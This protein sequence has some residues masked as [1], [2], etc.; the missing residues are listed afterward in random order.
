MNGR[1]QLLGAPLL[2]GLALGFLRFRSGGLR[3]AAVVPGTSS[4][5]PRDTV[6][7]AEGQVEPVEP[8]PAVGQEARELVEAARLELAPGDAGLEEP[9]LAHVVGRFVLPDGRPAVGVGLRVHGWGANL[10]R[11]RKYG[12]PE[13][14]VD[15]EG[16][17]GED[18]SFDLAFDPPQAYQFTL[19]ASL[20]GYAELS[21]RWSRLEPGA[22]LD[23][24]EHGFVHPGAIVGRVLRPDGEPAGGAWR[25][26]ADSSYQPAGE[27]GDRTRVS[28]SADP[29]DGSFRLEG[30]PPGSVQLKA[31]LRS[32]NWID[33]PVVQLAAHDELE[34][35]IVYAGPDNS[36]RIT[37]VT[38]SR[39]FYVFD[40]PAPGSITATAS[41]GTVY[42]AHKIQGSSQ[43]HSFEELPE[44]SYEL[45]IDDE[46]YL[47]WSRHGVRPGTSVDA[48]LEGSAAVRLAVRDAETGESVDDYA[49]ALRF[50]DVNFSPNMFDVRQ[51]GEPGRGLYAGLI[52]HATTL[53]VTAPGYARHEAALGE[54]APHS[55]VNA[56][57]ELARG[58]VVRGLVH[59]KGGAPAP[60]VSILMTPHFP[61]Y[62][63]QD[64]FSGP[65]GM[66]ARSA[67]QEQSRERTS[68]AHGR[69][70]FEAVP[71]GSYD[72][73]ALQGTVAGR[74]EAV[75]VS[76]GDGVE[77]DIELPG[78]GS[79]A[80]QVRLPDG[81][82]RAGLG[83]RAVAGDS[84]QARR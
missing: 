23:V 52:P 4:E 51:A 6:E 81:A 32:A 17:T 29:R 48:H 33:G 54:L 64:V 56:V 19:D 50:E 24:G 22:T 11:Q 65:S 74:T 71:A 61:G 1:H 41:D 60:G 8:Q 70:S 27:G 83:L 14:W 55:T 66:S 72:F 82:V 43:S 36:R 63:P 68:D 46:R 80:G 34:A 16:V 28:T 9:E 53:I 13:A 76:S 12:E 59:E 38:L 58:S 31:Y 77:V 39:P 37:V 42:V 5:E 69:F 49:L 21:W 25:V 47:P 7:V 15:P 26:Y 18:G 20:P 67:F 84:E 79:L 2:G 57:A 30:L 10:E 44:K 40:E 78:R 45:R 35:D 3:P 62:D 75:E 73:H